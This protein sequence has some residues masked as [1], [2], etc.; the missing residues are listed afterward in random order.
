MSFAQRQ[1]ERLAE[2]RERDIPRIV[3]DFW[4]ARAILLEG[5][6]D[7]WQTVIAR[8]RYGNTTGGT[9]NTL[10]CLLNIAASAQ[11]I[12]EDLNLIDK[13]PEDEVEYNQNL[14]KFTRGLLQ[15]IMRNTRVEPA[16]QRSRGQQL[17]F[18]FDEQWMQDTLEKLD[19]HV[20]PTPRP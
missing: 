16:K 15:H 5:I 7:Y 20:F 1:K 13:P 19:E 3:L 2:R 12:A 14:V 10:H 6:E 9:E 4:A 8:E 11:Q 17:C 18:V